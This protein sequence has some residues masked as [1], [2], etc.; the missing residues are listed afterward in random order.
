MYMR[1]LVGVALL[2]ATAIVYGASPQAAQAAAAP[3]TGGVYQ[4]KVTKSGMCLDV[5]GGS[6][7]NGALLQQWG[8]TADPGSG[9]PWCPPGRIPTLSAT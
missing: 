7:D 4:L 2:T 1:K 9:S 5:S 3:V 6:P 8:C